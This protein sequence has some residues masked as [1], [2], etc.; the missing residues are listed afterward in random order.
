[1]KI[2][3]LLFTEKEARLVSQ[4]PFG[5][6]SS[7]RMAL[8][9]QVREVEAARI[10][11][12][13]ADRAL[14]LDLERD[15]GEKLYLLPPPLHGF[16]KYALMRVKGD[17]SQEALSELLKQYLNV[18]DEFVKSLL[19]VGSTRLGRIM[20]DEEQVP[21]QQVTRVFDYERSSAAIR[22]A[23]AIAVGTCACRHRQI[24][25]GRG[26]NA[27]LETCL[28]FDSVADSLVRHGNARQIDAPEGLDILQRSREQGLVQFAENTQNGISFLCNCCSCCCDHLAAARKFCHLRPVATS[29]FLAR[30]KRDQCSGCGKCVDACPVE[31]IGLV[32]AHDPL[33]RWQRRAVLAPARCLGCGVCVRAC[34]DA[35]LFLVPRA[36]RLITPVDSAHRAVQMAIEEGKLQHLVWDNQALT[37]HRALA[38]IL[39]VILR[40]PSLQRSLAGSQLG[41]RYV[42]ALVRRQATRVERELAMVE[43]AAR[44][45]D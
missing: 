45:R 23:R 30:I 27:E 14:M 16:L 36:E 37:S 43:R 8:L 2:L 24:N 5:P 42:D 19:G 21:S 32:S 4:V 13:L 26:C 34:G 39:G 33:Y 9:W 11:D 6:F 35:A 40:L 15:N 10:L 17:A 20:V 18:E 38:A 22:A 31:A 1:M 44:L 3:A 41:S 29:N 12:G 7:A 28:V 25:L